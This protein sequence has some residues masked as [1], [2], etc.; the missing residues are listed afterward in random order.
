MPR[1]GGERFAQWLEDL[2]PD[3]LDERMIGLVP[4]TTRSKT[5]QALAASILQAARHDLDD[6]QQSRRRI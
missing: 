5:A 1:S 4:Y 3:F 6:I 2:P